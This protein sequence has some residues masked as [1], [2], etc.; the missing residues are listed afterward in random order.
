MKLSD[1]DWFVASALSD[2]ARREVPI[3]GEFRDVEH[4]AAVE[5]VCRVGES[6]N[7]RMIVVVVIE[8]EVRQLTTP[9]HTR[10]RADP[11]CASVFPVEP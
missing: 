4:A 2:L 5:P 11:L 10:R 9:A 1:D 3:E 8:V 6:V 7:L